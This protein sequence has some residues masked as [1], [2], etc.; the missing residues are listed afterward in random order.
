MFMIPSALVSAEL[1]TG[2]PKTGGIYVWVREA[3]GEKMSF[4][5]IWLNWVYNVVWFPTIMA[6]LAGTFT[7]FFNPEL[8]DSKLYMAAAILVLFWERLL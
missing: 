5:I 7:Y 1:G 6:L 2:W 3:F 4:I 8:A